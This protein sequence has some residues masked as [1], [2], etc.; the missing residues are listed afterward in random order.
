MATTKKVA[1]TKKPAAKKASSA[2]KAPAKKVAVKKNTAPVAK[3]AVE[4]SIETKGEVFE[5]KVG[6]EEIGSVFEKVGLNSTNTRTIVKAKRTIAA[7]GKT[8]AKTLTFERVF[9]VHMARRLFRQNLA[10]Q[11]FEKQVRLALDV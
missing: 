8:P 6:P 11:Q 10:R 3:N 1:A 4:I 9:N 2:K 5:F 7:S